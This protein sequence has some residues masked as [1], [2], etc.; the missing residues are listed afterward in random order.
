MRKAKAYRYIC[1]YKEALISLDQA[2]GTEGVEDDYIKS[3][4]QEMEEE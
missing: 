2:L 1:N 4:K 3:V